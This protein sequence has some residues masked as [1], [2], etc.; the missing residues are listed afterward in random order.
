MM[1]LICQFVVVL[2][3]SSCTDFWSGSTKR[4]F[5]ESCTDV[6]KE[7]TKN[8]KQAKNYCD[9]V[10]RKMMERYPNEEDAMLHLGELA[11]DT[12]LINCKEEV[13]IR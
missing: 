6:S 10:L 9:C 3:T 2:C 13:I 8:E 11:T 4:V 5:Y 1:Q 7:W 12:G